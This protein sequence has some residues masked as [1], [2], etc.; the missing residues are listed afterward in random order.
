MFEIG[1][2]NSSLGNNSVVGCT[3]KGTDYPAGWNNY[4]NFVMPSANYSELFEIASGWGVHADNVLIEN[5][6]FMDG[7][8]D[9]LITYSPCGTGKTGSAC[10]GGPPGAEGPSNITV[11]NNTFT[12]C[13][14]PGLHFNGG[15]I[16]HA[17]NNLFTDCN[18]TDEMDGNVLQV[19]TGVYW[20]NN[21]FNTS[22]FGSFNAL[23]GEDTGTRHSCNDDDVIPSDGSGC[24][25]VDN[26]LEGATSTGQGT[27]LKLGNNSCAGTPGNYSGN[28]LTG[29]A[30]SSNAC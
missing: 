16:L 13:G 10:N 30:Y 3:F 2:S 21:T 24:W 20:N 18:G 27:T 6:S 22:S 1:Y 19:M 23:N 7:Q 14:Q 5:N 29:G 11:Y 28:V 25:S 9:L 4:A 8:G 15:Q 17:A 26:T 12:H